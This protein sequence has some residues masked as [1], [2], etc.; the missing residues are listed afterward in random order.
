MIS[1]HAGSKLHVA[2]ERCKQR[3]AP[4]RSFAIAPF[5]QEVFSSAW[6]VGNLRT[7]IFETW[8]ASWS[9]KNGAK[10]TCYG[11]IHIWHNIIKYEVLYCEGPFYGGVR[12]AISHRSV[13]RSSNYMYLHLSHTRSYLVALQNVF[14]QRTLH[15]LKHV[16]RNIMSM[17]ITSYKRLRI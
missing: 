5:A 1:T 14:F 9:R 15:W 4:W 10:K 3:R 13:V 2:G 6:H 11:P 17:W 16:I 12:W 8:C 7:K